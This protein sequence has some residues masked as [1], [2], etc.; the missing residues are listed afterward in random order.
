MVGYMASQ[1]YD[2]IEIYIEG[3]F[4]GASFLF[5]S[6]LVFTGSFERLQE[7]WPI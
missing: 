7:I 5:F 2:L 1:V 4:G 3:F 6:G